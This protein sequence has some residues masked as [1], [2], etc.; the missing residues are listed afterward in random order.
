MLPADGSGTAWSS[1][2]MDEMRSLIKN[3]DTSAY[4]QMLGGWKQSYELLNAHKWQVQSYRDALE[5]VWPPRKSDAANAYVG[6]LTEMLDNLDQTYEA[7]MANYAAF[8]DAALSISLAQSDFDK[9]DQEYS[10]NKTLL[11]TFETQNAQTPATDE[12]ATPPVADGRQEQL[13]LQAIARLSSVSTD[14][15][16]AQMRLVQPTKYELLPGKIDDPSGQDG[17]NVVP[18]VLPPIT[19]S[20]PEHEVSTGSTRPSATFPGGGGGQSPTTPIHSQPIT[21]PPGPTQPIINTQQPGLILGG[22]T[23]VATAPSIGTTPPPPAFN[24]GGT[25][26][27]TNT[28]LPPVTPQVL[29]TG[30]ASGGLP[31]T[32]TGRVQGLPGEQIVRPTG[33]SEG[34]RALP[35]GGIIG[36]SA[37]GGKGQ[38]ARP[39]MRRVN[40]VGGMI[41]EEAS[42]TRPS[43]QRLSPYGGEP[44]V[45]GGRSEA[46]PTAGGRAGRG[47]SAAARGRN[48]TSGGVASEHP[49]GQASGRRSNQQNDD[50]GLRWDPDNPWE[51]AEGVDPVV[52]PPR[53]QRIDPGPAIGLP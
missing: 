50:E 40:P 28:T 25:G 15:A 34:I 5:A 52:M 53:E 41:G 14:L 18:P 35:P 42:N 10:N 16:Q 43:G 1:M 21:T 48:A 27:F 45:S 51:T 39:G 17:S 2:S 20:Y 4:Y 24:G 31:R 23:P 36:G 30:K 26:P 8:A 46:G 44:M 3:P 47:M 49:Y 38:A 32:G 37:P 11:S 29:P 22:T 19:A 6:R 12:K 33:V 7:A 13:R 9:I